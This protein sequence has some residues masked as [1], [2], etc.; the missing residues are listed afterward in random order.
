MIN[1]T[2]THQ[3]ISN[4]EKYNMRVNLYTER[5]KFESSYPLLFVRNQT[6]IRNLGKALTTTF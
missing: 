5:E 3:L 1:D 2:H 6:T 4:G